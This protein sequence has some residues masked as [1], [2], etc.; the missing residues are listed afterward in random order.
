MSQAPNIDG[1]LITW[2]DRLFYPCNRIVKVRPQPKLNGD[3]ARQR[4][5]AIRERIES[6]VVRR[7]PQVMVKVVVG[8]LI[9]PRECSELAQQL[10]ADTVARHDVQASMLTLHA[11]RGAAM[12][13]KPVASLLVDLDIAKSHSRPHVSDDNPYSE[14]QFKTMKYRPE[15][16]ARFGCIEDARAHCQTFFAWY[17][18][19]HCHSG[20]GYM[21]PRSVHYGLAADMHVIRQAT[22]DAAFLPIPTD[23]KASGHCYR[24]CPPPLGSIHHWRTKR[25]PV[26]ESPAH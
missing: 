4:A 23:S 5:A 26:N 22:L 13:S 3:S 11:D 25:R 7:A 21:T 1:L 24:P 10:I 2:G 9:A 14:S 15:F 18:D 8:W 19:E 6:T 17:N 16:P 20:V 12:R